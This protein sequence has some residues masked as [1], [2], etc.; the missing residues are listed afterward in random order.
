[1]TVIAVM[2]TALIIIVPETESTIAVG[3][4]IGTVGGI[5]T[6]H[7]KSPPWKLEMKNAI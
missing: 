6:D 5:N 3:R 7:G 2:I 1:M 4:E